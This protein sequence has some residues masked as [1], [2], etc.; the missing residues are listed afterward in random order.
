MK[1]KSIS[2]LL[3][4]ITIN[5]MKNILVVATI[6]IACVF[7]FTHCGYD[8]T[9]TDELTENEFK[10][11]PMKDPGIAGYIFPEDSNKIKGWLDTD[12]IEKMALHGWG[13]WTALTAKSGEYVNNEKLRVFETW[14]NPEDVY[15]IYHQQ[16]QNDK[17]QVVHLQRGRGNLRQPNQFTHS[18]L[19]SKSEA[20]ASHVTAFVKYNPAAADYIA[21]HSLLDTVQ[22]KKIMNGTTDI[23]KIQFPINS[24]ALKPT[25]YVL[26][27]M[28]NVSDNLYAIP[29]WPG[30]PS[31]PQPYGPD[32]IEPKGW[33]DKI[34]YINTTP[35][36]VKQS[37]TFSVTDFINFKLDSAQATFMA[38]ELIGKSADEGSKPKTGDYAVLVGMH[39]TSR[40]L[41]RWT[42]QTFWWSKDPDNAQSPSSTAIVNSRPNQLQGAPRHYA[43][44]IAYSMVLPVQPNNGG[45]SEGSAVYSY[46]PY[47]EAGF[48]SS[49]FGG[50][51]II[52]AGKPNEIQNTVGIQTNC[53]T[54]HSRAGY[55]TGSPYMADQYF[56]LRDSVFR[57]NGKKN[58]AI[59]FLW[60]ILA[61]AK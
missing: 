47:L 14:L 45:S 53:M 25:F 16:E 19:R 49:T 11:V 60:S 59:D 40:E 13:L 34:V 26:S 7:S 9:P 44:S 39:V 57:V 15:N 4:F 52:N 1:I 6:M 31:T 50:A 43:M 2:T 29:S 33:K 42:W 61:N 55:P 8:K 48:S 18:G 28:F 22:L 56:P 24:V 20:N 58:I 41:T 46:N 21:Q 3:F 17:F 32:K 30:P 23:K 5:A 38:N 12:D 37:D 51:A 27:D 54:C 10:A 36:F 35:G